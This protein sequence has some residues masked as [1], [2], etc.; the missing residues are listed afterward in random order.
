MEGKRIQYEFRRRILPHFS[1]DDL[2]AESRG[3]AENS[4]LRVLSPQ[5]FFFHAMGGREGIIDTACKTAET[6][7]IQRRLRILSNG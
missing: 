4:Y 3:F 6:G 7:Y 5:E 1:K 2:G